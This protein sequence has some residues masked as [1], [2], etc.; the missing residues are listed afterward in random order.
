MKESDII[1]TPLPLA[2]GIWKK[3][4]DLLLRRLPP[5]GDFLA[6]DISTQIHQAVPGFDEVISRTDAQPEE[7]APESVKVNGEEIS[8]AIC[9]WSAGTGAVDFVKNL[10]FVGGCLK[11]SSC[12]PERKEK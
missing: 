9:V 1:L 6:C 4:P 12:R 8:P 10:P 11:P 7:I 2:D 5:F 3:R